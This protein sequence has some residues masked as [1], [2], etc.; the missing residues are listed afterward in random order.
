MP[1]P[2]E[3]AATPVRLDGRHPHIRLV[4]QWTHDF[5]RDSREGCRPIRRAV[6]TNCCHFA[7]S[8]SQRSEPVHSPAATCF[9]VTEAR[10]A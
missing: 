5:L 7:G 8:R 3:V 6:S 9:L 1:N 2:L 4:A 10:Q